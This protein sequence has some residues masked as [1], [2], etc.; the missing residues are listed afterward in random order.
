MWFNSHRFTL[1][2]GAFYVKPCYP[3]GMA[4]LTPEGQAF[5]RYGNITYK[6]GPWDYEDAHAMSRHAGIADAVKRGGEVPLCVFCGRTVVPTGA[7]GWKHMDEA[8]T[9]VQ[10][11]GKKTTGG[12]G[13]ADTVDSEAH[14][15]L[16][17]LQFENR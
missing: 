11:D 12:S 10:D 4:K 17:S 2:T 1:F 14:R 3:S 16:L 15:P 7:S 6:N 8:R 13:H 5:L 9:Q